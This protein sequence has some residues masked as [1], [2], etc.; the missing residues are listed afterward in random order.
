MTRS[1]KR[2]LFLASVFVLA[3]AVVTPA[4]YMHGG[5]AT[6]IHSCVNK[7]SGEIKIVSANTSCKN[8]ETALDWPATA[9]SPPPPPPPSGGGAILDA[10]GNFSLASSTTTF[11]MFVEEGTESFVQVNVPRAGQLANLFVHPTAPPASGAIL[12]VTVRVNGADTLLAVTH[13]SVDGTNTVSNTAST[14]A[15]NQGDFVAVKFA[16]SGGSVPGAVYRASFE[17]K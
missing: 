11:A 17:L 8:H 2:W 1:K 15:V 9:P 4:V 10:R 6:L 16:E 3:L 14:V 13:T 5:D 12:T 7:S